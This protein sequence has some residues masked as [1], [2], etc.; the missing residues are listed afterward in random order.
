MLKEAFDLMSQP[1]AE[2]REK[3]E[4]HGFG[5]E[6]A[7]PYLVMSELARYVVS[8]IEGRKAKEL[9][10]VALLL[11]QWIV[12]GD[13]EVR[14]AAIIG[15]IEDLQNTNLHRSTSPEDFVQYLSP[16]SHA[17]WEKAHNFWDG[18]DPIKIM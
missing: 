1:D 13:D 4:I 9:A 17:W 16:A 2:R 3:S 11:E 10:T 14:R 6:E 15:L 7:P 12:G 18:G 8:L 5:R